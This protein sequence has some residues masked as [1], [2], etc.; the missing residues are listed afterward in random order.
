M[1]TIKNK[2]QIATTRTWFLGL[3]V[4][5]ATWLTAG[6]TALAV[7]A[8]TDYWSFDKP[9]NRMVTTS[10]SGTMSLV[11]TGYSYVTGPV[12]SSDGAIQLNSGDAQYLRCYHGMAA[13]G[14]GTQVNAYTLMWD[15]K[16]PNS[17]TWKCLL[18]TSNPSVNDGDIFINTSGAVGSSSTLGG[19]G[20]STSAGSWYRIVLAVN[21][22]N[23]SGY[24]GKL[25]VNGTNVKQI[26]NLSVDST[27]CLYAGTGSFEIHLDD[28]GENDTLVL[29]SFACWNTNLS[30]ADI[31]S[32]GGPGTPLMK[33]SQTI[34]FSNP[35]TQTY[36]V[37][38]ITLSGSSDSGLA[39]S[40]GVVSGPASV[41]GSTL[42][43]T[44]AGSVTVRA[45]QAGDSNF[46]AAANADQTFTVN[47]KA[48]T[49]SSPTVATKTYDGTTA[50]TITGTLSG[51]VGSDAV[52]LNGTGTFNNRNVGNGKAVTSTSALGGAQAGNYTLTQPSG[53]TGTVVARPL[54]VTAATSSK[55]YDGTTASSGTPTLASGVI[56][57]GDAAPTWTQSFDSS[58]AS[59]ANGR[60]L[61]PAGTVN[62][63]NG[64]GNYSY[65][66]ATA[67]GTITARPLAVTA[68]AASKVY[69]D[70]D[71]ALTFTTNGLVE[72]DALTGALTRAPGESVGSYAIG[73]GTLGAGANYTLTFSG[74]DLTIKK[75]ILTCSTE[76][77]VRSKGS[78]N[79]PFVIV[80]R[81]FVNG[82]DASVLD[83]CP[84]ATCDAQPD[85][86]VGLYPVRCE[87]GDDDNYELT[88][89]SGTLT[90]TGRGTLI[91][92]F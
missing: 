26:Y 13:N 72:G 83:V 33:N 38:P 73:Q 41:N 40:Y 12:S 32:L 75:A 8:P 45:S 20:G 78:A 61:T 69:G 29:S 47:P 62:D 37:S 77:A 15:V 17:G 58:N 1:N 57:A 30:D 3:A 34:T 5:L 68:A 14:G 4:G 87:G 27:L 7:T 81:G 49:V 19:Y 66:Y 71:P 60:T 16:Y 84:I 11:G 74:A 24:D 82:E 36:G 52:T 10:G 51:I 25:F 2:R 67:Q 18:Q 53:L 86:P 21:T 6:H 70:T 43:I 31:A 80:Y 92:V 59:D 28:N 85:V 65:T 23:G 88:Y 42:T 35:G 91:R 90:V 79:P 44:G 48:L 54:T 22:S 89:E 46:N 63:G 50:A 39:L 64:G 55:T 9:G 76:P 56:Q